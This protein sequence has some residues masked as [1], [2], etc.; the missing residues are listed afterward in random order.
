MET[1]VLRRLR[2]L[3]DFEVA[4]GNPDVRGWAIRGRDGQA[5]GTV[6]EMIVNLMAAFKSTSMETTFCCPS[7]WLRSIPRATMCSCPR[8]MP[9]RC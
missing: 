6:F 8:S 5:L 1:S 2:D 7:E 4:D 9:N 3:T